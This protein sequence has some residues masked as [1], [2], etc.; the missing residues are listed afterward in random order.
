[1]SKYGIQLRGGLI[2]EQ[3]GLRVIVKPRDLALYERL[4]PAPLRPSADPAVLVYVMSFKRVSPWPLV[5]YH[6]GGVLVSARLD[7][8]E[9]WYTV[10]MPV[11]RRVACWGGR[12]HGFPKYVADE[13]A[14]A[15]GPQPSGVVRHQGVTRIALSMVPDLGR[16]PTEWERSVALALPSYYSSGA[17]IYNLVPPGRGPR[18]EAITI[19][20]L[21]PMRVRERTD[22][23]VRVALDP[24]APW[25]GLVDA[26]DEVLGTYA[27]IDCAYTLRFAVVRARGEAFRAP[28][29]VTAAARSPRPRAPGAHP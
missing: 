14:F 1:M 24:T 8:R 5:P 21:D 10:T 16:Q 27:W 4:I 19:D 12:R 17:P 3:E 29:D 7:E 13:I 23:R 28:D 25:A 15:A 22:G 6:E 9:G 18:L 11:D 26:S 2:L 20:H